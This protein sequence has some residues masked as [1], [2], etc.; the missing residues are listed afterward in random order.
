MNDEAEAGKVS[1]GAS[2]ARTAANRRGCW[3][4][5]RTSSLFEEG[6]GGLVKKVAKNHQ[7]LGVNKAIARLVELREIQRARTQALGVF[8]H[9]QGSGKSLSMVFFS[10][11]VLRKVPGNWTF[12]IVTDREELDDQ[13]SKTFKATGVTEEDVRATSGEHL[14]Q[15]LREDHRYVFT[16]IQKFRT[17]KGEAYPVLSER[18]D[19]IVITD[20][21]HRSQY[22]MFALNMR[23]ALPNAG[24]LGFT[25]T[26]LI[27]ARR[28]GRARCSATTCPSTTSRSRS[29]TAPRC[30]CTTRTASPNC[31]ST[32]RTSTDDLEAMVEDAE[33]DEEQEKKLE[34]EFAREYHLITREDRLEAI[35]KDI[36]AH[37]IGRGYRGKAMMISIDKATA[38]RMYDKVQAHWKAEIAAAEGAS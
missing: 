6:K 14:R 8:W 28:S 30:R 26:P 17:E 7:F 11:K 27:A 20:E 34:R 5:S 2:D 38:V 31:S 33:L 37:F 15:L 35:A 12:V 23:N 13:I 16:L 18:E 29:R 4:T 21:A 25:G 32:N 24:F 10:Q 19:V 22:D 1:L 3:T 9:T 36:V